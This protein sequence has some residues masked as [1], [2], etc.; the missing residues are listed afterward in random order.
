MGNNESKPV[1]YSKFQIDMELTKT[2]QYIRLNRNRKVEQLQAKESP[3]H[4]YPLEVK[5]TFEQS[6]HFGC[7]NARHLIYASTCNLLL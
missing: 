2:V 1:G 5:M 4:E 3:L 7:L 6:Y